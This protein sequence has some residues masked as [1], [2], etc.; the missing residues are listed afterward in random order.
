MKRRL[1]FSFVLLLMAG[2]LP[3]LAPAADAP[4]WLE[5]QQVHD[6]VYAIVGPFGNRTPENLGNNA[7]F[8]VVITEAGVV[9]ID[10][11]GSRR[12]AEAIEA[13]IRQV[14]DLPVVAVINTGGQ[15]HRW[16]G[17]VYFRA[18]GA[19]IIA[20]E[21]AVRDHRDR[22]QDQLFMLDSLLG[23]EVLA[24]TEPV[25]AEE[26]FEGESTL[27]IGGVRFELKDVGP[28]HTPGD[29]LVWLPRE[30]IVFTGDVVYVGRMLGVIP[31]SSSSNWIEAFDTMAAL[32]PA[33]IVPGHGPATDIAR[34]REDTYEYLVFLR[35][36]VSDFMD[37]GGDIID[38]GSLD[39][40]RFSKLENFDELKGRNAQQVFQEMEWE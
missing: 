25:Y 8:G 19:R 13:M 17:N 15:D 28:A 5:L 2:W 10:A 36:I 34:A 23:T 9:L 32:D 27:E 39:Q 22:T 7:T 20:S 38:I 16:L 3:G 6:N 29:T 14:S 33:V 35:Q 12:G 30:R 26:T 37:G 31:V 24:G 18:K 40:A 4:D 11:G 21:A 1:A